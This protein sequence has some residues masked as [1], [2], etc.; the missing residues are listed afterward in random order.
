[1]KVKK[2]EHWRFAFVTFVNQEVK[3]RALAALNGYTIR[4]T[5]TE[6]ERERER[7]REIER[8]R[9]RGRVRERERE[10]KSEN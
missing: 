2:S 8:D 4:Y 9:E 5:H 10:I 7:E 3:D 6:R 1:M